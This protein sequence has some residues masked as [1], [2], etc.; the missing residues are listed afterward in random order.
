VV[1]SN[2]AVIRVTKYESTLFAVGKPRLRDAIKRG[3]VYKIVRDPWSVY[4]FRRLRHYG[5]LK[6]IS[7]VAKLEISSFLGIDSDNRSFAKYY[8]M[9]GGS[10]FTKSAK[11]KNKFINNISKIIKK[12]QEI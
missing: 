4:S 12:L 3:F 1:A 9:L 5:T 2:P 10:V 6:S 8:P 7:N 11:A